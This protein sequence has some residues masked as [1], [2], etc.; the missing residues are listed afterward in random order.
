MK[1]S[2]IISMPLEICRGQR[3]ESFWIS[4]D[5]SAAGHVDCLGF[6][7]QRGTLHRLGSV[8]ILLPSFEHHYSIGKSYD[9]YKISDSLWI[10]SKFETF[11]SFFFV[12][13]RDD[14]SYRQIEASLGLSKYCY[15]HLN[16]IAPIEDRNHTKIMINIPEF[17]YSDSLLLVQWLAINKLRLRR[18]P[19]RFLPVSMKHLHVNGISLWIVDFLRPRNTT[20]GTRRK[21]NG[22][23]SSHH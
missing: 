18:V 4:T 16:I 20:Q 15:S 19:K 22:R 5:T 14:Y 10:S 8:E 23:G 17:S 1:A 12:V 6:G 11:F 2:L 13:G 3:A 21:E 9:P 7:F